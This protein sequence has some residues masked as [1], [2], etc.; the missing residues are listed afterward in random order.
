M[1]LDRGTLVGSYELLALIDKGAMGEVYRAR[2]LK[3]GRDV[4]IKI[5]LDAFAHDAD[6]MAV[7]S[8]RRR[9]WPRLT[10]RIGILSGESGRPEIYVAPFPGPGSKQQVSTGGGLFPLWRADGKKI[11]YDQNGSL[12]A[13]EISIKGRSVEAGAVRSLGIPVGQSFYTY[14]VSADGQRFV[15]AAPREQKSPAPLTLVQNW[16]ALLKKK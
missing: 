6:R 2:D 10:I 15:V 8:V 7:S 14:A 13:A 4:A 16:T 11:Y 12:M 3:L 9:C 5:L 1:S